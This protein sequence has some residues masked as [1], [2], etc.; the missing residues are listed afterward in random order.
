MFVF[1]GVGFRVLA[2]SWA[3]RLFYKVR[4]CGAQHCWLRCLTAGREGF[5]IEC[6][7]Q[8][9]ALRNSRFGTVV[10]LRCFVFESR[11]IPEL[12]AKGVLFSSR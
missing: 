1:K 6:V 7:D 8:G 9:Q 10:V 4:V 2:W 11:Q 5:L 3:F 12:T